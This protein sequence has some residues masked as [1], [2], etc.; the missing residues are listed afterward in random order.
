MANMEGP[1]T[2]A[3]MCRAQLLAMCPGRCWLLVRCFWKGEGLSPEQFLEVDGFPWIFIKKA[4]KCPALWSS[5]TSK[6]CGQDEPWL[7]IIIII[8]EHKVYINFKA[9]TLKDWY[10][11]TSVWRTSIPSM[12]WESLVLNWNYCINYPCFTIHWLLCLGAS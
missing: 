5:R 3:V 8:K 11:I 4:W 10:S 12:C 7:R 1:Y 9:N 6:A 2:V